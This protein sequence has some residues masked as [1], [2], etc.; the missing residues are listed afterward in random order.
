MYATVSSA[1]DIGAIDLMRRESPLPDSPRAAP[2]TTPADDRSRVR[3]PTRPRELVFLLLR[4]RFPSPA[5]PSRP[6]ELVRLRV[7]LH[8]PRTRNDRRLRTRLND[9]RAASDPLVSARGAI[10]FP[11]DDRL[12]RASR[13]ARVTSA[14]RICIRFYNV[15]TTI[16]TR[17]RT[18]RAG[19]CRCRFCEFPEND[20]K[21]KQKCASYA[22]FIFMV[23]VALARI[24][25]LRY[26]FGFDCCAFES[27]LSNFPIR[28][29]AIV[30]LKQINLSFFPRVT[31]LREKSNSCFVSVA[32]R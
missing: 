2:G 16:T 27:H 11:D 30:R 22:F 17:V 26:A 21:K 12:V 28:I 3:L 8:A 25:L 31:K 19:K 32:N 10:S 9:L 24:T 7:V 13:A 14:M 1:G 20:K 6:R 29:D 4:Q 15:T 5:H 23:S 18:R